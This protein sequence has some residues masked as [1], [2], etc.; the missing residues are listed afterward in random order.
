M[1]DAGEQVDARRR[2]RRR[3]TTRAS[4]PRSAP[5]DKPDGDFQPVSEAQTIE[6]QTTFELDT[7]GKEFRYYLVWITDARG[8]GAR[9]RGPRVT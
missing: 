2:R 3:R 6:A 1:L 4:P 7:E 5:R 8:P 9:E